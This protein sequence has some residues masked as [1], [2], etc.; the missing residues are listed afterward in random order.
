MRDAILRDLP[1]VPASITKRINDCISKLENHVKD[2]Y[3]NKICKNHA[4][5]LKVFQT[6]TKQTK[7]PGW[8]KARSFIFTAS[9]GWKFA[10]SGSTDTRIRYWNNRVP[11]TKATRHGTKTEDKAADKF[12]SV[13]EHKGY[14][15]LKP[16]EL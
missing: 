13:N 12:A 11:K 3:I 8:K 16:G 4:G 14:E 15:I 10:Q 1:N 6:S 2:F 5:F 7:S 9:T